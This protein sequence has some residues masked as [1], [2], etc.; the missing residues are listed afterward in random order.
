[1]SW[2]ENQSTSILIDW[3]RRTKSPMLATMPDGEILWVNRAFEELLGYS[4]V[5]LVGKRTWKD[6]TADQMDLK[7]DL[8]LVEETVSGVRIDYQLQK[9]YMT[10]SGK[11]KECLIDVSRY[12]SSG[13]F[14]CFLVTCFP[15]DDGLQYAMGQLAQIRTLIIEL[16]ERQP[17]GLTIDKIRV[18]SKENP[19][20]FYVV[21]TILGTLLFGERVVEIAR[22]FTNQ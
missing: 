10:K 20:S 3:I 11:A 7:S 8:A 14:E 19:I 22:L 9:P 13:D 4:S 18:I 6:L 21:L 2:I 15:L 5:E 16:M 17:T 12:P 1:M